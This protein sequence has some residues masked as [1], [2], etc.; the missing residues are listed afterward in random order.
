MI[1]KITTTTLALFFIPLT[2]AH[3][4][5]Y[6]PI[7]NGITVCPKTVASST[8]TGLDYIVSPGTGAQTYNAIS[9]AD[10]EID[11]FDIYRVD[12]DYNTVVTLFDLTLRASDRDVSLKKD[13][14]SFILRDSL[15]KSAAV[16]VQTVSP[17]IVISD[18]FY[19]IP[20]GETA[21]IQLMGKFSTAS[22]QG[23]FTNL[24]F[25]IY[26]EPRTLAISFGKV[27]PA[28]IHAG[29]STELTWNNSSSINSLDIK[30]VSLN[31]G[32]T[33]VSETVSVNSGKYT[34]L[35]SLG[36]KGGRYN[37]TVYENK[38]KKALFSQMVDVIPVP[39][40]VITI[41]SVPTLIAGQTM[42]FVWST[43]K[44]SIKS[45]NVEIYNTFGGK[46]LASTT[47]SGEIKSYTWQ[48]PKGL[49]HR[50][51]YVFKV[52]DADDKL[53]VSKS[54]SFN[55]LEREPITEPKS[56]SE[57]DSIEYMKQFVS[58]TSP[59]ASSTYIRGE[60][61]PITLGPGSKEFSSIYSTWKVSLYKGDVLKKVI[62]S[63]LSVNSGTMNYTLPATLLPGNDYS[64]RVGFSTNLKL[65]VKSV[66][67]IKKPEITLNPVTPYI[68]PGQ[69]ATFTWTNTGN[70]K[71]FNVYVVSDTTGKNV[72]S[73][74]LSANTRTYTWKTTTK[75]I[76]KYHFVVM[77]HSDKT[78]TVS[79][80]S[81]EVTKTP[82]A[83]VTKAS[84]VKSLLGNVWS[85]V[86]GW[87]R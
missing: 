57:A 80:Q 46:T 30:A 61:L 35:T 8:Y 70:L 26:S 2:F 15:G 83:P 25:G 22:G 54:N 44:D 71:S 67:E 72:V 14:S 28:V 66:F 68:I 12:Q 69:A 6:C 50:D 20:K 1:K 17:N 5:I 7:V 51:D 56:N 63:K 32:S 65:Y 59:V 52:T 55:V 36:D 53:N 49:D 13:G 74:A 10:M 77:D 84:S 45:F 78:N 81:F 19:V 31:S 58:M 39:K 76:G 85:V 73:K 4:N 48:V 86:S 47:V 16:N 42:T 29:S 82:P 43:D 64:I 87:V 79:S 40:P 11:N 75:T 62:S 21:E 34:W 41:R 33:A 27:E 38:T 9:P 23:E 18:N 24:F 60:I 37:F 3:A